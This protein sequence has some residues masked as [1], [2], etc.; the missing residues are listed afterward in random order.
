MIIRNFHMLLLYVELVQ[1]PVQSKCGAC[2]EACPVKIP[3]HELLHKHRQVIVEKEG[4]APVSEKLL[5][6]AFGLGAASP[7]LYKMGSRMAPTA[8]NPLTK[9]GKI[10]KGVGPLKAWT[11]IRDFPAPG[12]QRF[13]D[14]FKE[15]KKEG[16]S[17]MSG[18]IQNRDHFLQ[19]IANQL[20]REAIL[21]KPEIP[22]WKYQPQATVLQGKSLDELVGVLKDQ[23]LHI[24]TDFIK[25]T[26]LNLEKTLKEMVEE[27]GGGPIITWKDTRFQEYGLTSLLKE[28]WPQEKLEVHEW[29]YEKG[30]ANIDI[31]ETANIGITISDITLAESGTVVQFSHKD[32]GRSV[33]AFCR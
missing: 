25:T 17:V 11:E 6:K 33:S 32:R 3:L 2:T 13:R 31:A 15:H 5:M 7:V 29:N 14:W 8:L 28:K 18:T 19:K 10:T 21:A 26:R 4:R 9:E 1:K 30:R 20:G 22:K 12:K 23:C 24:H 16:E 27:Y